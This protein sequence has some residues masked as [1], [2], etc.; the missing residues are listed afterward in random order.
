MPLGMVV[1]L[2]PGDFVLD[3]DAA[4]T[5]KMGRSPKFSAHVYCDNSSPPQKGQSPQIFGPFFLWPNGW[6]HQDATWYGGRPQP[7][8][9]CVR[10]VPSLLLKMGRSPQFL[11]R[12]YC[13]QTAGWMKTPLGREVDLIPDH[14]VLAGIPS[15]CE[16]GTAA[17]SFRPMSVVATD[18]H[19]SY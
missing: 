14:I 15:L 4:S 13:R 18:A 11:A 8:W 9:L 16:R 5:P 12:V 6:M 17:P 2:S 10:C 19:L 1:G 7:T 3:G